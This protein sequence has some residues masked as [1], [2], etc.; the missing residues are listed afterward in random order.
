MPGQER[1]VHERK[2]REHCPSRVSRSG[3]RADHRE[4]QTREREN[5]SGPLQRR[6]ELA[7]EVGVLH[8]GDAGVGRRHGGKPVQ[9]RRQVAHAERRGGDEAGKS[10]AENGRRA[11]EPRP[12]VARRHPR[13]DERHD[14]RDRPR[15]MR[16][17]GEP[18]RRAR[19]D[20]RPPRSALARLHRQEQRQRGEERQRRAVADFA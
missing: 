17:R 8:A 16:R 9:E 18:C 14:D 13:G 19:R 10:G 7:E 5:D 3:D 2:A 11:P 4:T 1:E 20:E 6:H 15:V 12:L